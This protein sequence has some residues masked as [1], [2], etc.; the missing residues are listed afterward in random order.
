MKIFNRM[1]E[2]YPVGFLLSETNNNGCDYVALHDVDLIPQ[3][4]EVSIFSKALFSQHLIIL[5]N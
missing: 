2:F 4:E 1:V 5:E 3:N